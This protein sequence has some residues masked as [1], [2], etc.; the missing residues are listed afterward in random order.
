MTAL[1]H[2]HEAFE[3]HGSDVH[4]DHWRL[5][6]TGDGWSLIRPDGAIAFHGLGVSGRRRCLE[7]AREHGVLAV[8]S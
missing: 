7:F 5:R 2:G 6:P 3:I 1:A 8:F 4:H